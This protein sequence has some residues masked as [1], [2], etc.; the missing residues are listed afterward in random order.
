MADL[1][2]EVRQMVIRLL[3]NLRPIAEKHPDQILEAASFNQVLGLAKKVFPESEAIKGMKEF[4][5]VANA[6]DLVQR[7]SVLDGAATA[8]RGA[9]M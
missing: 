5:R 6:G 7:L 9:K 1:A 4:V 3:E 8:S 2:Q